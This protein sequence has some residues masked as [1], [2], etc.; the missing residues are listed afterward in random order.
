MNYHTMDDETR[1]FFEVVLNFTDEERASIANIGAARL[2]GRTL[3]VKKNEMLKFSTMEGIEQQIKE[4]YGPVGLVY[5]LERQ[6]DGTWDMQKK[7]AT[8]INSHRDYNRAMTV[9]DKE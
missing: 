1:K 5:F 8:P 6:P 2:F 9:I 4:F 7:C 3:T